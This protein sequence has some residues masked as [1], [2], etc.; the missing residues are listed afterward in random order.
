MKYYYREHILGYQRVKAEG[1]TA[2][3]EIHGETGFENF[4]S[5]RFLEEALPRLHFEVPQ[6]TALELGCGTGPGACLLAERGFRVDGID[7]I[8]LAIEMAREQAGKR[9]LDIHFEVM[10]VCD[11][12]H[13]G[14][15]YDL[16]VDSYCLQ[17]IV[18]DEDRRSVF[19]AVRARLKSQ[20]YYLVSSAVMD[21]EHE[22]L[23]R[24]NGSVLDASTG[25]AYSRY[26]NRLIDLTTGI[27][28]SPFDEAPGD[29]PDAVRISG[30]WYLPYRRHLKPQALVEELE[31][32]GFRVIYHDRQHAGSLACVLHNQPGGVRAGRSELGW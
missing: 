14:K 27:V 1:K 7:L 2:W 16:I 4:A 25:T 31:R 18:F 5:R 10:D 3:R 6:P 28:Y 9:R 13:E 19:S 26:G 8:P 15:K 32:A 12:P 30:R 21:A 23:V 24:E 22:A 11:L 20:G 29:F 17:C